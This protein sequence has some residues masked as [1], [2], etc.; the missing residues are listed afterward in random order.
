[1]GKILNFIAKNK[2]LFLFVFDY[3]QT[4]DTVTKFPSILND[5]DLLYYKLFNINNLDQAIFTE[6]KEKVET[7]HKG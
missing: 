2:E 7:I 1:M 3:T 4:I 6:V 5:A